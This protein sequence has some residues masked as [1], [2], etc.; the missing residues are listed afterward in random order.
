MHAQVAVLTQSLELA[1][2]GL[3]EQLEAHSRVQDVALGF[4][5]FLY[6]L[7]VLES[8]SAALLNRAN[9]RSRLVIAV[10]AETSDLVEE[11]CAHGCPSQGNRAAVSAGARST[12][13]PRRQ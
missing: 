8:R 9:P 13:K 6:A 5:H 2:A 7:V 12:T 11:V 4:L 1:C 10:L 3:I